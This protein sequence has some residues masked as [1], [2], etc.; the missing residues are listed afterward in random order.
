[1][2]GGKGLLND[3][4]TRVPLI[5]SWPGT[6]MKD[7]VT[8]S[9]TDFVDVLPTISAVAGID[10]SQLGDIDGYSFLP[11]LK[12]ET[13]ATKGY[14]FTYFVDKTSDTF[15]SYWARTQRWKL[16]DD[17]RLFDIRHDPEEQ[18]PITA[19]ED[20][21]EARQIRH[22]LEQVIHSLDL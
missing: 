10:R 18:S 7:S 22:R 8:D 15:Q 11:L 1:M 14:A 13:D 20:G 16:Y 17:G 3:R 19:S 21:T 2:R 5:V 12:G 9:I 6:V 4:G